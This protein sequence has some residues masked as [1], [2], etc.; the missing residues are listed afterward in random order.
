MSAQTR[1]ERQIL[2]FSM[3]STLAFAIMG[4]IW[5]LWINSMVVIFDGL[6]SLI[7][8][9]MTLVSL[10]ALYAIHRQSRLLNTQ[11]AARIEHRVILFK[12]AVIILLCTLS[13]VLAVRAILD[14]GR[15]TDGDLAIL[16]G[17]I[18]VVGCTLSWWYITKHRKQLGSGLINAE[19][20]QWL[21][22]T[23]ISGAV[24]CGFI[25]A[26][27]TELTPMAHLARYADPVMVLIA[28]IWF[29][30]I[31]LKMVSHSLRQLAELERVPQRA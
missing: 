9:F 27:L 10:L 18:N 8:L 12:G 17:L 6:Y 19:E 31:P 28:S 30:G 4:V 22:D 14:G 1:R 21:M 20:K 2:I 26:K 29:F 5:G 7:G 15:D 16:F 24:M 13:L 11:A 23:V 3:L 25:I